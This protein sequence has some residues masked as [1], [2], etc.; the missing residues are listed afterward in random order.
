MNTPADPVL[1]AT[2]TEVVD[3]KAHEIRAKARADNADELDTAG[4]PKAAAY[5]R[6]NP[7]N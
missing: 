7:A 5:L 1:R 6:S 4:H 2:V 3:A